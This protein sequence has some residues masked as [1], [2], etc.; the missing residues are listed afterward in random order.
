MIRRVARAMAF[1][2]LLLAAVALRLV[3]SARVEWRRA[4]GAAGAA[5]LRH[6]GRAARLYLPG[7]PYSAAAVRRLAEIGRTEPARAEGAWRELRSALWATRSCYTPHHALLA[8]ANRHLADGLLAAA[9]TSHL[10]HGRAAAETSP[11]MSFHRDEVRAFFV[12]RLAREEAPA[13]GASLLAL[14]GLAL[15]VGCALGLLWRGLTEQ[16]RYRGRPT[17]VF[18]AGVA[19]GLLLFFFGLWRA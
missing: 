4:E 3:W 6:L 14:V 8:E 15:F 9:A 16:A 7:N 19:S 10:A 11:G 1:V 12:G 18:A 13:V 5:E 2:L 17:L